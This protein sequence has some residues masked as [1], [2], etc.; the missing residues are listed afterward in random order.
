MTHCSMPSYSAA[1]LERYGGSDAST[2]QMTQSA[3]MGLSMNDDVNIQ[4]WLIDEI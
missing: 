2:V 4:L 1:P 3:V